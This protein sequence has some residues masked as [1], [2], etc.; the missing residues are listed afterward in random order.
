MGCP[1][2]A[3]NRTVHLIL[4]ETHFRM[5]KEIAE[6]RGYRLTQTFRALLTEEYARISPAQEM[7]TLYKLKKLELAEKA[8]GVKRDGSEM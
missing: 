2:M 3:E 7:E 1:K 6:K 4:N 5:L 8:L